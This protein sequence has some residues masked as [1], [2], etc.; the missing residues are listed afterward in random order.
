MKFTNQVIY[1]MKDQAIIGI[2]VGLILISGIVVTAVNDKVKLKEIDSKKI[3]EEEIEMGVKDKKCKSDE[4]KIK[5]SDID[6]LVFE[7]DQ[8]SRLIHIYSTI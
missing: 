5:S 6:P 4:D 1:K 3:C 8:D 7:L 2:I